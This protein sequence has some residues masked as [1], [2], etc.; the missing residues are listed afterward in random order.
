MTYSYSV[1]LL[2]GP[3]NT[4]SETRQTWKGTRYVVTKNGIS[5]RTIV[6][7]SLYIFDPQ[8]LLVQMTSILGLT[9]IIALTIEMVMLKYLNV[10]G[11]YSSIK[12][13]ESIEYNRL[14]TL[15]FHGNK[16]LQNLSKQEII[17]EIEM[18]RDL[19][20]GKNKNKNSWNHVA[21]DGGRV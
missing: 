4:R 10:S 6:D 15:C 5:I 11:Y 13:S 2:K 21:N 8:T 12:Y 7:G 18:Q 9:S 17:S 3:S 19:S 20:K 16:N 1:N 14:K